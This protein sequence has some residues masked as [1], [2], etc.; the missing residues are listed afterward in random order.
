MAKNK[1]ILVIAAH[2]DDEILGCGGT[3]KKL[4]KS[5]Y[6]SK[7]L[8]FGQGE[9]SRQR[10]ETDIKISRRLNF[11][12]NAAKNAAKIINA[13]EP[14]FFNLPDNKLD[15]VPLIEII[16]KIETI[17]K[18]YRPSIIFTHFPGDLNIDHTILYKA[19]IT[20]ARPLLKSTVKKILTYEVL[21]STGWNNLESQNNF[22]PNYF[23]NIE[24]EIQSKLKSIKCYKDEILK[25]PNARSIKSVEYLARTR[26]AIIG[27]KFAEAFMLVRSIS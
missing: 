5:G 17:I 3:I 9:T 26:G 11:L 18:K 21:S 12:Q 13:E 16:K 8:I 7:I 23:V 22:N 24:K 27:C 25:Y 14:I 1:K 2:P 6:K 15:T 4:S 19:T 10:L 20:A